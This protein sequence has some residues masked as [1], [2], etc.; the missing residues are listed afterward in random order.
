MTIIGDRRGETQPTAARHEFPQA[1]WTVL[2]ATHGAPKSFQPT[3]P[4][5]A[6]DRGPIESKRIEAAR[7]DSR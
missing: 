2:H 3:R 4:Q 7:T 6:C 5:R 1:W